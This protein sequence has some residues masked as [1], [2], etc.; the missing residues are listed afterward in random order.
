MSVILDLDW[1]NLTVLDERIE[2]DMFLMDALENVE[3]ESPVL[4]LG[5]GNFRTS[6]PLAM[7]HGVKD[8]TG[9]DG[10]HWLVKDLQADPVISQLG[11]QVAEATLEK[12][13]I[14]QGKWGVIICTQTLFLLPKSEALKILE[15]VRA[16]LK[17]GGVFYLETFH[18]NDSRFAGYRQ[19][20]EEDTFIYST[21]CGHHGVVCAFDH[22]EV[23]TIFSEGFKLIARDDGSYD[24]ED[25]GEEPKNLVR[26]IFQKI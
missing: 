17:P 19:S 10:N 26:L 6:L 15:K 11:I 4:D 5:C 16:G 14:G 12:F 1:R 20:D 9:V 25:N 3:L 24:S 22:E 21:P 8:I 7:R 13:E 2:L 18:R 23:I